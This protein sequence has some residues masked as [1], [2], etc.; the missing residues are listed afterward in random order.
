M[1]PVTDGSDLSSARTFSIS[2]DAAPIVTTLN[3]VLHPGHAFSDLLHDFNKSIPRTLAEGR[4]LPR[5]ASDIRGS[6]ADL[7][8]AHCQRENGPKP[9]T[10]RR[11]NAVDGKLT[12]PTHF[13]D[14][15]KT[16]SVTCL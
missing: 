2:L 16:M 6:T 12:N 3:T 14:D 9:P 13:Y 1:H 10:R 11:S 5:G 4:M 15:G 7:R 8:Y